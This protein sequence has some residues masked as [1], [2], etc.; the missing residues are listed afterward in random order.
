MD[1]RCFFSCEG[2]GSKLGE[3]AGSFERKSLGLRRKLKQVGGYRES[4]KEGV[5][6]IFLPESKSSIV[7]LLLSFFF[8]S[9]IIIG[10]HCCRSLTIYALFF[11]ADYSSFAPV[12]VL[13][14]I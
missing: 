10:M 14:L 7:F 2:R 13:K 1:R 4:Q 5:S 11:M 8:S 3:D 9:Y 12:C 6:N